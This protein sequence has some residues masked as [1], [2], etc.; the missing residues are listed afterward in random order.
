MSPTR[1]AERE[2]Q[3]EETR[4]RYDAASPAKAGMALRLELLEAREAL[5]KHAAEHSRARTN[6]TMHSPSPRLCLTIPPPSSG[7]PGSPRSLR[8]P[9]PGYFL[10][11]R[12]AT[13]FS[14]TEESRSVLL[15]VQQLELNRRLQ[16]VE[17]AKADVDLELHRCR[18]LL[19]RANS[20]VGAS[21]ASAA[22]TSAMRMSAHR[23]RDASELLERE[24]EQQRWEEQELSR[25]ASMR[26]VFE[27]EERQAW[28]AEEQQRQAQLQALWDAEEAELRRA[29]ALRWEAEE[30]RRLAAEEEARATQLLEVALSRQR[31]TQEEARRQAERVSWEAAEQ[32]RREAAAQQWEAEQRDA[33]LEQETQRRQEQE[34]ARRDAVRASSAPSPL[35]GLV[36][37]HGAG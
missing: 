15:P 11:P 37:G 36:S 10:T 20:S 17:K 26:Q 2:E 25:R 28:E 33:R 3:H 18:S 22:S 23:E 4:E 31:E 14:S 35:A 12:A 16:D 7:R 19:D 5:R 21:E 30:A 1:R 6:A 24:L 9:S 13:S 29:A 8:P 27:A 34:V 32:R